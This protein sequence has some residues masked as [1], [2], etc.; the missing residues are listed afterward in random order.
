MVLGLTLGLWG[1]GAGAAPWADPGDAGLRHD[2]ELLADAGV[3][4]GPVTTWPLP[5]AGIAADLERAPMPAGAA[6]QAAVVRLRKAVGLGTETERVRLHVGTAV[7]TDA[8]PLR[9]FEESPREKGEASAAVEW[10]GLRFSYRLKLTA[11][12][13]PADD[14]IARADDSYFGVILGNYMLLVGQLDRW[15][16]PG[17]QGSLILSSNARPIPGVALQRNFA[18]APDVRGLRWIGPWTMTTLMGQ[19]EHGRND[20]ADTLFFGFRVNFR[21]RRDLE[22]GISRTAQWCGSGRVCDAEAFADLLLGRDNRGDT[23]DRINEPG[24]QLAG[25]DWRW[26]LPSTRQHFDWYGQFVGEDEAG[27]LPSRFIG[28]SGLAWHGY[29][30]RLL[31]ALSAR[32][33]IAD[34]TAEFYKQRKRFDYAYEHEIYTDGYRYR[35]RSIGHAMDNDGRMIALSLMLHRDGGEQWL[36]TIRQADLNRGGERANTVAANALDLLNVEFSHRR[37]FGSGQLSVGVGFDSIDGKVGGSETD[38]RLHAA[39]RGRL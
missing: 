7:A 15:W 24:N 31:G 39:W 27:G 38:V 9:S 10:T 16:G 28:L 30:E 3:L 37:E 35:R 12:S 36:A 34:T 2:I 32:L 29:S 26:R 25:F 22:I 17:W 6:E 5:W 13:D 33:E 18:D 23:V 11:V 21:P 19:M 4:R 1:N 20:V 14:L 8:R